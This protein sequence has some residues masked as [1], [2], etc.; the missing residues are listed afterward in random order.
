MSVLAA[1]LPPVVVCV[2]FVAIALGV[3][4]FAEREEREDRNPR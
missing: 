1:L 3:K 4:R 2:A